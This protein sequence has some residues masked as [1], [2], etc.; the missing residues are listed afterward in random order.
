LKLISLNSIKYLLPIFIGCSIFASNVSF[1]SQTWTRPPVGSYGVLASGGQESILVG[2]VSEVT[3]RGTVRFEIESLSRY[4][5]FGLA[6][7][8]GMD[9]HECKVTA[10]AWREF[11]IC[12]E[13]IFIVKNMFIDPECE[14]GY[15]TCEI[16]MAMELTPERLKF[17]QQASRLWAKKSD[18]TFHEFQEVLEVYWAAMESDDELLAVE[19]AVILRDRVFDKNRKIR[20]DKNKIRFISAPIQDILGAHHWSRLIALVDNPASHLTLR[21]V[22]LD[23]M[24]LP[25]RRYSG[26]VVDIWM[27]LLQ[28]RAN[29]DW[30]GNDW[31]SLDYESYDL[32]LDLPH[33]AESQQ[34]PN[35]AIKVWISRTLWGTP[36][37]KLSDME[38]AI[39][40]H[41]E[42]VPF[43]TVNRIPILSFMGM[44]FSGYEKLLRL[45]RRS[46]DKGYNPFAWSRCA[47]EI[48]SD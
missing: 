28:E 45:T 46:R 3:A 14:I 10:Y 25:C 32:N 2:I 31:K 7:P 17:Y 6:Q 42:Q 1:A 8:L 36:L 43:T 39:S 21:R 16:E 47:D 29:G 41:L 18:L 40:K 37:G 27:D 30:P 38:K 20:Q 26:N 5:Q 44:E 22:I 33:V 35:T 23:S 4:N 12:R 15:C 48:P 19:A 13:Y 11:E 9:R 24:L 34:Y